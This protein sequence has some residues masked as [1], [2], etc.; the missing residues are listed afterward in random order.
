MFY[1]AP[2]LVCFQHPRNE[3]PP[4]LPCWISATKRS[5]RRVRASFRL[6]VSPSST[7]LIRLGQLW[8]LVDVP[9]YSIMAHAKFQTVVETLL[10]ACFTVF[11]PPNLF[12][13]AFVVG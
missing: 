2:R 5:L 8:K 3:R 9:Y 1:C 7:R 11:D 13:A 6:P 10:G 12:G 4:K